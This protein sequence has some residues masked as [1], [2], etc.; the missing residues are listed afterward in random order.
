MSCSQVSPKD[1][2]FVLIGGPSG[3]GKKAL[4]ICDQLYKRRQRTQNSCGVI[5][6]SLR[7]EEYWRLTRLYSFG[8]IWTSCN[9]Q[10][11]GVAKG[12]SESE[13]LWTSLCGLQGEVSNGD[14]AH[15]RGQDTGVLVAKVATNTAPFLEISMSILSDKPHRYPFM[16]SQTLRRLTI[17]LQ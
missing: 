17:S 15:I 11:R 3:S 16:K 8:R 4:Y 14:Y 9:L 2:D 1:Y 10:Y 13:Y 12:E 5:Q 7:L 6:L